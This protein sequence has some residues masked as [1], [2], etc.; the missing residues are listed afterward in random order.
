MHAGAGAP[1]LHQAALAFYEHSSVSSFAR[2]VLCGMRY[3]LQLAVHL[4]GF[5]LE[6]PEA[7]VADTQ[8]LYDVGS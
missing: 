4:A 8:L 6:L 7:G 1:L 5:L 3:K 2:V